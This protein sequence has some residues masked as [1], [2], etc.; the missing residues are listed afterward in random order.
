MT[1]AQGSVLNNAVF[2]VPTIPVTVYKCGGLQSGVS[3]DPVLLRYN[4]VASYPIKMKPY[5]KFQF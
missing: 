3:E 4:N 1:L 5:V 2:H